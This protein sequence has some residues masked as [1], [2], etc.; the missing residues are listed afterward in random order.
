[1][2]PFIIPLIVGLLV[3]LAPTVLD[4]L[5]IFPHSVLRAVIVAGVCAFAV[6]W[7][8]SRAARSDPTHD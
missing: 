8:A 7:L 1:M 3:L 2:R 4:Q 6:T 5:N